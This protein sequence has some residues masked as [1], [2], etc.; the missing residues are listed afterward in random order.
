MECVGRVAAMR[1]RIG[2]RLDHLWNSTTEPGQPWVMISGM[3]SG[4]ATDMHEVNAEPIDLGRELREAVETGFALRQSY[5][6]PSNGRCPGSTSAARL[7][8]IID[9]FGLRPAGPAQS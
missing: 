5:S 8:P 6:L 3:A 4:W 7:A 9:Q 1:R 2:E